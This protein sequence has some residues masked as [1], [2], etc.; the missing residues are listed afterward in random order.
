MK[1][2]QGLL[3]RDDATRRVMKSLAR[4]EFAHL[5][6]Y[7]NVDHAFP[8]VVALPGENVSEVMARVSNIGGQANVAVAFSDTFSMFVMGA[9]S[10][11]ED[12]LEINQDL[13][14]GM[15]L[16]R[17]QQ[18]PG[19]KIRFRFR[20]VNSEIPTVVADLAYA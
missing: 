14:M 7:E 1:T 15:F 13:S 18:N 4:P 19:K 3:S 11:S 12:F 6:V 5:P 9:S 20:H 8:I 16:I 2:H 10:S 17:V